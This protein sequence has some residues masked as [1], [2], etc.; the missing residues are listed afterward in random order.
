MDR[1][2]PHFYISNLWVAGSN[3]AGRTRN[4]ISIMKNILSIVLLVILIGC[5][6]QTVPPAA[7]PAATGK[8]PPAQFS[9]SG[10]KITHVDAKLKFVVLDYRARTMPAIGTRLAVYR[11]GQH[12]GEVQITEPV[13]VSFAT[14][15]IQAGD[16]R[17]GDE[18]R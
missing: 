2:Y 13:R 9:A 5:A 1:H 4:L 12:V 15:D 11:A 7:A 8:Q 3:D 6:T 10:A 18:A 16:V 14:A 17:V